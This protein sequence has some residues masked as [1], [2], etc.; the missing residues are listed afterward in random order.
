MCSCNSN[1]PSLL[2]LGHR[3]N[4]P[5][6][7]NFARNYFPYLFHKWVGE[8]CER[9]FAR[10]SP[11]WVRGVGMVLRCWGTTVGQSDS[12]CYQWWR[13]VP[14]LPP[15]QGGEGGW[16]GDP[17]CC[18]NAGQ[19][20]IGPQT[21]ADCSPLIRRIGPLPYPRW[22]SF[23]GLPPAGGECGW[24]GDPA[25]CWNVTQSAR[26]EDMHGLFSVAQTSQ[27]S[28]LSQVPWPVAKFSK[29]PLPTNANS[30]KY[31]DDDG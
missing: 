17:S 31:K 20:P 23:P 2:M 3:K 13:S 21:W 11:L 10:D 19:W 27:T 24:R 12:R 30:G 26:T 22:W 28:A 1:P 9:N 5:E 18:W 14:V 29:P 16:R 4:F 15:T 6:G 25:C 7:Q 8:V